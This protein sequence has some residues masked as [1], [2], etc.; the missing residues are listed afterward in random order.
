MHIDLAVSGD[1]VYV[2]DG[3]SGLVILDINKS[4]ITVSVIAMTLLLVMLMALQSQKIMH[5]LRFNIVG[6]SI[7][8]TQS[9]KCG[10]RRL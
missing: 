6:L 7:V 10:R 4:S 2:A 5:T 3:G 1:H 9:R 8:D